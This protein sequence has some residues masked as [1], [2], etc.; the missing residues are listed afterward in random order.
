MEYFLVIESVQ[1]GLAG[2]R[3]DEIEHKF[4]TFEAALKWYEEHMSKSQSST[5][6]KYSYP[7]LVEIKFE[8]DN[9][10]YTTDYYGSIG[11]RGFY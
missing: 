5:Y 4:K 10:N 3:V 7:K 8:G 1:G 9:D 11:F 6:P 2:D